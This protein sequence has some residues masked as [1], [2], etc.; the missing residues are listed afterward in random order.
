MGFK[1]F[2]KL[3]TYVEYKTPYHLLHPLTKLL[4]VVIVT[5]ICAESIWWVDLIIG[6][7]SLYFY[8]LLR[9]I[10]LILSFSLLQMIGSVLD[11]SYFVSPVVLREIFGNNL[12]I[13]W[14]FPSY[15]VFMGFVPYLTLQA[16]IY[17]FQ[18]SMRIWTM[19]MYSGLIFL[20]T[21]PSQIIRSFHKMKVPMS[22]TFAIT[23]GLVSLPRI[24]D[25]ADT[26]IK[27]QLMKGIGYKKRIKF[28]YNL[29]AMFESIIPLF[30]YEFKKAKTVSIS[31]ETRAFMAYKKRTYIDDITFSKI[32]KIV[33]TIMIAAL[34]IDTY[35]VIVGMIP[36]IPFHP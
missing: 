4:I 23:V 30:I 26:I 12:T 27:L 7:A 17:S 16:I 21:T 11:Y 31:A 33:V 10:R 20:T 35:L 19:L 5:I 9:R 13:I 32:D 22:I 29:R 34:I 24:F 15:F 18:V 25:T 2:E 3:T 14:K 28:L 8:Y 36:S 1:G 6:I